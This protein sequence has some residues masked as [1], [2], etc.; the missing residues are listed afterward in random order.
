MLSGPLGGSLF[1]R[2]L[3]TRTQI[4]TSTLTS[5]ATKR[6]RNIFLQ[7][8]LKSLVLL[9][10][11]IPHPRRSFLLL[12]S[13]LLCSCL[14]DVNFHIFLLIYTFCFCFFFVGPEAQDICSLHFD[15]YSSY[16]FFI[17]CVSLGYF[18]F[19]LELYSSN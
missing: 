4:W 16:I 19:L 12:T 17:V 1:N 18:T 6:Q 8:I 3:F 15:K 10:W 14:P 2:K 5:Q 7:T 11:P 13:E 9:L